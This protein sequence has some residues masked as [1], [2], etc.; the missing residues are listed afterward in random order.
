VAKSIRTEYSGAFYQCDSAG[1]REAIFAGDEDRELFL[2]TL[3][4]REIPDEI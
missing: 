2:H 3:R 4:R 1:R